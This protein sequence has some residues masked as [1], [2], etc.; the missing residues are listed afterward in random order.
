MVTYS[1]RVVPAGGILS[2]LVP[3]TLWASSG[4][5]TAPLAIDDAG[6]HNVAI[7]TGE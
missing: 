4:L 7:C 1:S 2:A 5:D 3:G 6:Q